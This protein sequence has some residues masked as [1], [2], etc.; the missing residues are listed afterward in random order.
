MSCPQVVLIDF[1][2][3]VLASEHKQVAQ[4][5]FDFQGITK[6]LISIHYDH[7]SVR[8][9]QLSDT[10]QP[11]MQVEIP[12]SGIIA[13]VLGDDL[14]IGIHIAFGYRVIAGIDFKQY[15]RQIAHDID[16]IFSCAGDAGIFPYTIAGWVVS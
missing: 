3:K 1:R 5:S 13:I 7:V 4:R 14:R 12:R 2:V 9:N 11:V 16:N 6:G 15:H 10:T 8:I